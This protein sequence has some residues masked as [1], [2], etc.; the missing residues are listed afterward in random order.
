MMFAAS[1]HLVF[2]SSTS[3]LSRNMCVKG[4]SLMSVLINSSIFWDLKMTSK[5]LRKCAL[6]WHV[7]ASSILR[8]ADSPDS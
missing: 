8:I 5:L 3:K 4:K 2:S 1:D 6:E 7:S